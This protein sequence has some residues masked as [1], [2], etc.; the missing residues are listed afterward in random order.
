MN[1]MKCD[2]LKID[3]RKLSLTRSSFPRRLRELIYLMHLSIFHFCNQISHQ[4]TCL[5]VYLGHSWVYLE[6][7][8]N[9]SPRNRSLSQKEFVL[10][11]CCKDFRTLS[12]LNQMFNSLRMWA[13]NCEEC[14]YFTFS[15]I[16]YG[17]AFGNI[18][19]CKVPIFEFKV[20]GEMVLGENSFFDQKFEFT[21]AFNTE[22]YIQRLGLGNCE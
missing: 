10:F 21:Q 17:M 8:Q 19:L 2:R 18:L 11:G 6:E 20:F 7:I 15:L 13:L 4:S 16:E 1:H 12:G 22:H 5:E 3:G 9:P 14:T